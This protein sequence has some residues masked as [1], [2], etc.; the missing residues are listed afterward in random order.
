MFLKSTT[1]ALAAAAALGIAMSGAAAKPGGPGIGNKMPGIGGPGIIKPIKPIKPVFPVKPIKPGKP[2]VGPIW[3]KPKPKW[4]IIVVRP[5]PVWYP[6]ATP[7]PV[8]SPT[9]VASRPAA[10]RP[11][12]CTCLSKEY[13]QEGCTNEMAMNP[14]LQTP[15]QTGA[16]DTQQQ[17]A[18][19]QQQSVQP[20]QAAQP[21]Q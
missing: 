5:R 18:Q 9:Y 11:G 17:T 13:T 12:P 1:I 19:Y 16:I 7:V 10:S 21:Q 15:R 4:P 20:Q 3:P 6:V 2:I 8:A 14:P